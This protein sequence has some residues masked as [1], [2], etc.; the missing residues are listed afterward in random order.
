MHSACTYD[1]FMSS[2]QVR[3]LAPEVHRVLK[4]RAAES[5]MSLSEYTAKILTREAQTPTL[6]EFIQ[7]L[8]SRDSVD[9]GDSVLEILRAE[10]RRDEGQSGAA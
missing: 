1:W 8:Q 10:R 4:A 7:R 6:G 5:G 2:L 3:D 9:A